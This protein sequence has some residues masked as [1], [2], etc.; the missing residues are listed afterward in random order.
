MRSET[1]ATREE[2]VAVVS[3]ELRKT[4][5]PLAKVHGHKYVHV[6]LTMSER[7]VT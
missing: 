2:L 3:K 7:V 4:W 6:G 5:L 1:L